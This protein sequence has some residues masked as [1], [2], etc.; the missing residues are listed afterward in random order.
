MFN[1]ILDGVKDAPKKDVRLALLESEDTEGGVDLVTLDEDGDVELYVITFTPDGTFFR[2]ADGN[3]ADPD[4][5]N[6]VEG[7]RRNLLVLDE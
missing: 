2:H 1:Y 7:N 3:Y 6:P 4:R 5:E